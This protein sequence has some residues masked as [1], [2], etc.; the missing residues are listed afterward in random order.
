MD[1]KEFVRGG[2]A[3]KFLLCRSSSDPLTIPWYDRQ[4]ISVKV[5][6]LL[7]ETKQMALQEFYMISCIYDRR[8]KTI[9]ITI[10]VIIMEMLYL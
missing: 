7:L 6:P 8:N 1:L 3:L 10:I 9:V 4:A 2:G 5:V